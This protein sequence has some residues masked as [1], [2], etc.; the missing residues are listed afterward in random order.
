MVQWH[1]VTNADFDRE[2]THKQIACALALKPRG[3]ELIAEF[4][5]LGAETERRAA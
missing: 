3:A 2:Q 1:A 4:D 5:A